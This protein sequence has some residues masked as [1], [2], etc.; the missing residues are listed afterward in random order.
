MAGISYWTKED[1]LAIKEGVL[2]AYTH[3]EHESLYWDQ[4]V[5]TILDKIHVMVYPVTDEQLVEIDT[6]KE[7]QTIDSSYYSL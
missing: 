2:T 4:V 7:L 6:V 5:D 1:A 3:P